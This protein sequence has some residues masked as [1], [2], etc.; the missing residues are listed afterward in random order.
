MWVKMASLLWMLLTAPEN[1]RISVDSS[2]TSAGRS[3]QSI[4][5]FEPSTLEQRQGH[6]SE[7]DKV[8]MPKARRGWQ[9]PATGTG[10]YPQDIPSQDEGAASILHPSKVHH[11]GDWAKTEKAP[12]L[13]GGRAG[14]WAVP[15]VSSHL[16][17]SSLNAGI[18]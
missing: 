13:P 5:K 17:T 2:T 3:P 4:A 6:S 16:Y 11:S 9:R 8:V 12:G 15:P 1:S 14:S 18:S 10:L 7:Q